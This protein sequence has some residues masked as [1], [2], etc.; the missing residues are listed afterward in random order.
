[1]AFAVGLAYM[2]LGIPLRSGTLFDWVVLALV[3]WAGVR[4]TMSA[5]KAPPQ[6][7]VF[8]C[9]VPQQQSSDASA[10]RFSSR[11]ISRIVLRENTGREADDMRM[12]QMYFALQREEF[13]VLAFQKD[14]GQ[15]QEVRR[16]SEEL[17]ER[18]GLPVRDL[19]PK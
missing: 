10:R 12:A 4:I 1:M 5:S 19:L 17:S 14:F 16:V 3:V 18:W 7:I 2:F 15:R 6:I 11:A 8:D 9:E 13:A